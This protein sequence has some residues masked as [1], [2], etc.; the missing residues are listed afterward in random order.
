[1]GADDA[2]GLC[3]ALYSPA[4]ERR[5]G[6][7][8]NLRGGDAAFMRF[9]GVRSLENQAALMRHKAPEML[10]SVLRGVVDLL[11]QRG[12]DG[13]TRHQQHGAEKSPFR[14]TP[15]CRPSDTAIAKL[16]ISDRNAPSLCVSMKI[17][18]RRPS[19]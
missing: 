6:C 16:F 11:R 3:E 14:G 5:L 10:V 13:A 4:E 12:R 15:C 19:A 9:V 7:G 8:G 18:P 1:M 2:S 17:S